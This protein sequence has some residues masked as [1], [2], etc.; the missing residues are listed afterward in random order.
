MSKKEQETI[1]LHNST[2]FEVDTTKSDAPLSYRVVKGTAYVFAVERQPDGKDGARYAVGTFKAGESIAV[3]PAVGSIH[4]VCT[5]ALHTEIVP[6]PLEN[7]SDEEQ[8]K[9]RSLLQEKAEAFV[10]AREAELQAESKRIALRQHTTES[11]YSAAIEEIASVLKGESV[12]KSSADDAPIVR[13][14]FLVCKH[15]DIKI[16]ALTGKDYTGADALNELA[17]DNNIR[18]RA[19]TLK[20]AWWKHDNGALF[21]YYIENGDDIDNTEAARIPVALLPQKNGR[22]LLSNPETGV[23]TWVDESVAYHI[24]PKAYM[25]YRPFSG[26]TITLKDLVVF[27]VKGFAQDAAFFVILGFLSAL[28]GLLIPELTRV[29]MDSII[30]QAAKSMA[31]Q[32][33]LLVLL[34]TCS[35]AVFD[36]VK[37]LCLLR[38]QIRADASLQSAVMDR[39]LKLPVI[40]FRDY[41]AG[42]LAQKTMAVTQ[43]QNLIF[44]TIIS[45]IMSFVFGLVYL[46]QLFRYSSYL[47]RWAVVFCLIPVTVTVIVSLIK[48]KWNKQLIEISSRISGVLFQYISGVNKLVMTASE[49]RAFAVWGGMFSKQ[50]ACVNKSGKIDGVY[51]TFSAILSLVVTLLFYAIFM[52]AIAKNKMDALTTGSFMAFMAAFSSFQGVLISMANSLTESIQIIPLY[53]QTKTILE[54]APEI[55]ESK[56]AVSSLSGAIEIDHISFRYEKDGPLILKDVSMKIEPGEFVAIVGGSGSGKSTLLRVLLGFETPEAG[57]IFFDNE[58]LS[59]VDLSSVRRNM[60]VVLQNSTIMQGSIFTNIVGSSALT[61]VDAWKAAE[62]AGLADDIR[63]MPMGMHTMI[64]A[65]GGTISGGQRQRLIIARAIAR[66]PNILVF[67]E[68]TSALDN[69][70]QAQVSESL[71][72]LKVTRIVIAHRLSTI[73]HADRIYVLNNGVIEESGTYEELMKKDGFFAEL[74]RRQQV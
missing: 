22:Y 33:S 71:E 74:A 42:D 47:L 17:K 41:T 66:H 69:R 55:Q 59:A 39:L 6:E 52:N 57:S 54:C 51:A 21:A 45:S 16:Q 72:S 15:N 60:G 2:P 65:G 18:M 58:D 37:S 10:A 5:G 29:F 14:A 63:E 1:V 67:D 23:T 43:I 64:S 31:V 12:T 56:P 4:F 24:H 53:E 46:F 62:M 40:F 9:Q 25:F 30:P 44:G 70:T 19:V 38:M 28:V 48:Y 61:M 49:K 26:K 20:D 50:N 7:L 27:T 68:A 32:I 8:R 73:I 3:L 35:A 11:I 36:C 13:V 34:C